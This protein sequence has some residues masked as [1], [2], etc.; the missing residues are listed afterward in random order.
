MGGQYERSRVSLTFCDGRPNVASLDALSVLARP[1]GLD[2]PSA[3]EIRA[4]AAPPPRRRRR[5]HAPPPP[6]PHDLAYVSDGVLRLDRGLLVRVQRIAARWPG[7]SIE[8]LSGYRPRARDTSRHHAGRALDMRV[9]G[10]SRESLRDFARAFDATGVG[11][12]PNSVFVHVDVREERAYWVDR[13]LPG[14]SAD[15]GT[16]PPTERESAAARSDALAIA[17]RALERL[18]VPAFDAEP[19]SPADPT[20]STN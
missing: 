20:S 7:R 11:Y 3:A 12:Y 18:S 4:W 13:S 9:R 14:D 8:I 6:P 5:R 10:V 1:A 2:R 15:Y 16:W 17:E 19:E